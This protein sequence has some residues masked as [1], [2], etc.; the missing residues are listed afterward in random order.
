MLKLK[1]IFLVITVPQ[2]IQLPKHTS[3]RVVSTLVV[4][5]LLYPPKPSLTPHATGTFSTPKKVF[6]FINLYCITAPE[7]TY[8]LAS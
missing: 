4:T 1:V 3:L 8:T 5:V 6:P 7:S 2:S